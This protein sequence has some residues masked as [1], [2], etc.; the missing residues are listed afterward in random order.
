[1]PSLALLGEIF[2][3]VGLSAAT[4]F[5]GFGVSEALGVAYVR[6]FHWNVFV[7]SALMATGQ[8]ISFSLLYWFGEIAVKHWRWF[9]KS[10]ARVRQRYEYHLER[11][12]LAVSLLGAATGIPPAMALSALANGF[13]VPYR[14][15]MPI[16]YPTRIV[17]FV[18][19]I[20]FYGQMANYLHFLP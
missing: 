18:V 10:V 7:V 19:L 6:R 12:F 20:G 9:G 8:C 5:T 17:R 13:G 1:M 3:L 4:T 16:L 15:L 2:A 14:H 11:R